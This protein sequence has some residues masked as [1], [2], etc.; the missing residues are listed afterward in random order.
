MKLPFLL[1]TLGVFAAVLA[2]CAQQTNTP[3]TA[4]TGSA[5]RR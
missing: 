2:G 4:P 1:C 3:T 5:A